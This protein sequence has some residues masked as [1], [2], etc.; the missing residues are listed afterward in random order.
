VFLVCDGLKGQPEVVA[1]AWPATIVQ[2]CIVYL[3]R[4]AFRLVQARLGRAQTPLHAI[5]VAPNALGAAAA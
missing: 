1:N 3:I 2:T 5:Y 4:N